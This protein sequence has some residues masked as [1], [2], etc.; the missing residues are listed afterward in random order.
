[1]L[2][3]LS[4]IWVFG[5]LLVP[6][7]GPIQCNTVPSHHS[8]WELFVPHHLC[9]LAIFLVIVTPFLHFVAYSG[10]S[11]PVFNWC[12]HTF[13]FLYSPV[14]FHILSC[15]QY[16][17]HF[18][19]LPIISSALFITAFLNLVHWFLIPPWFS[20]IWK[21]SLFYIIWQWLDPWV[22]ELASFPLSR[23]KVMISRDGGLILYLL[24]STF[25][26]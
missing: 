3:L 16:S 15:I 8:S 7:R 26:H 6:F 9:S 21:W 25:S 20:K 12:L 13:T 23:D 2:P 14:N 19:L 10:L 22:I 5:L 18:L 24:P 4:L 17:L 1:M 11:F